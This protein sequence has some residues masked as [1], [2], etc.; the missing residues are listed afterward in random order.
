MTITH[1]PRETI[2]ILRFDLVQRS[3]HWANAILFGTL[4]FTAIRLYF[5]SFFGIVL[6]RHLIEQIHLWRGL[7]LPVPDHHLDARTVG[8]PDA[9]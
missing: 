9:S 1:A 8:S 4:M 3:A 7:A 2:K 6:P 5:G